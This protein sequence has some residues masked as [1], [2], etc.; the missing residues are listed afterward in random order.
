MIKEENDK[1]EL[2]LSGRIVNIFPERGCVIVTLCTGNHTFPKV[3]CW[4]QNAERVL[5][6]YA[7]NSDISLLCNFQSSKHEGKLT[8]SIFC[9]S[10][11]NKPLSDGHLYNSFVVKGR[12]LSV[13]LC[14][15]LTKVIVETI[16]NGRYS[17]IPICIYSKHLR[18][19]FEKNQ[20]ICIRGSVETCKKFSGNNAVFFT[21]FVASHISDY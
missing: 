2:I 17:T 7:V 1:N 16:T 14:K 9:T 12:I 6:E 5:N 13:I 3:V 4:Q 8:T 15:E 20:P 18:W 11:L 21:N 10:I 19:H